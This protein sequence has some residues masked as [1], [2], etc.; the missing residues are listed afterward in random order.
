MKQ[1]KVVITLELLSS[2]K[3][4]ELRDIDAWNRVVEALDVESA[5]D[6]QVLQVQANVVV[7]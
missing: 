6:I 5:H 4:N 3:L 7:R 1:R 2:A